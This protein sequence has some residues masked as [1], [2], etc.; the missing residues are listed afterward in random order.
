VGPRALLDDVE[1]R[2]FLTLPG[3]ELFDFSVFQPVASHYTDCTIVAQK[4][5]VLIAI[6]KMFP[7]SHLKLKMLFYTC[8]VTT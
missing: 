5:P 3:L 2:K 6:L 7:N 4:I 8:L 1:K